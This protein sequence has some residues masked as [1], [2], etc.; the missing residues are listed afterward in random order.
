MRVV[1]AGLVSA[2]G[3]AIVA[4]D[5]AVAADMPV[6]RK[7]P[8]PAVVAAYN[9]T[10]FYAGAHVG[11][12]WGDGDTAIGLTDAAGI[13]QGAAALGIFPVQ[14]SYDRDGYVAGGQIGYNFQTGVWVLGLEADISA[15]GID[16]SST[17][18]TNVVGFAFPNTSS[19]SQDM[20]WFGTVRGRIG[21]A[22]NNWLFYGTGGLAYGHVKYTYQQTNA[23]LGAINIFG[24]R[25]DI[26]V[27]WVAGGGI[28]YG[29]GPWSVR[30][31]YLYYDLGDATFSVPHNLAPAALFN[32]NFENRGSI[33]R[34]AFNYRFR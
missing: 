14:Y 11:Y 30:A 22:A 6:V 5:G 8:A 24:S 10:G 33:V 7:A 20:E 27:G 13:L 34:A 19:V 15:T 28:E 18:T 17:V 32:P 3:L 1:A 2:L 23:P 29:F 12:G 21:Y 26:E 25:S 31:E 16:G 9:W 4:S